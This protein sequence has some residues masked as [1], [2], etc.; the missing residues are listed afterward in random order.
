[1][2]DEKNKPKHLDTGSNDGMHHATEPIRVQGSPKFSIEI[3]KEIKR[4]YQHIVDEQL[5]DESL[6]IIR[7]DKLVATACAVICE[8]TYVST[9]LLQNR[10]KI[11]CI[12][13]N[14]LMGVLEA[15][16]I[17]GPPVESGPRGI[18]IDIDN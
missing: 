3:E 12:T 8:A 1:M 18:L 2:A 5:I 13:A 6:A 10:L 7:Q 16:G 15:T 4:Q 14:I 11:S 17:I 9:S